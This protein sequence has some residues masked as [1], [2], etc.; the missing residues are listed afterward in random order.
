M[1]YC[2]H[3]QLGSFQEWYLQSQT[4]KDLINKKLKKF[5]HFIWRNWTTKYCLTKEW[6]G[7]TMYMNQVSAIFSSC[8]LWNHYLVLLHWAD[9]ELWC[10]RWRVTSWKVHDKSSP[11]HFFVN[12]KQLMRKLPRIHPCLVGFHYEQ[13]HFL[14]GAKWAWW[15]HS[16]SVDKK[17]TEN[18]WFQVSCQQSELLLLLQNSFGKYLM[19]PSKHIWKGPPKFFLVWKGTIHVAVEIGYMRNFLF[20]CIFQRVSLL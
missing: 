5:L 11:S 6:C 2:H 17:V 9:H 4:Q 20:T 3:Y 12:N 1:G 13:S 8:I 16:F 10:G 15:R 19:T 14:R 7:V 18:C